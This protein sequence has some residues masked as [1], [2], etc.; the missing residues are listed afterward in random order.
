MTSTSLQHDA[1]AL[2]LRFAARVAAG[3]SERAADLPPDVS[4]RLRFAR[5]KALAQARTTRRLAESPVAVSGGAAAFGGGPAWWQRVASVLPLIVL[6]AGLLLI[7]ERM[8]FEQVEAAAEIDAVLLADDLPPE[9]YTD[10]GFGEF[11]K[12]SPP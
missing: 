6:V 12:S 5:E 1:E 3:L 7:Q 4:E 9:A 2:T 11:L 10:P 8:A